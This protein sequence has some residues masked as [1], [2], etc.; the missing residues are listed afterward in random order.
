MVS[1]RFLFQ[2]LCIHGKVSSGIF[3]KLNLDIPYICKSSNFHFIDNNNISMKF[4]YKDG[5]H[6]LH[7][8][9]EL[10]ARNFYFSYLKGVKKCENKRVQN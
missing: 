9:K 4:L 6:Y 8:R 10:L 7:S 5:L 2:V 1:A 3:V